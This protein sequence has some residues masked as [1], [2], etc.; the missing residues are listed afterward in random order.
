LKLFCLL[1]S[2][3]LESVENLRGASSKRL[4]D[5][6]NTAAA[7][8]RCLHEGSGNRL[9]RFCSLLKG[10]LAADTAANQTDDVA[11]QQSSTASNVLAAMARK[12][13]DRQPIVSTTKNKLDSSFA[14]LR[15]ASC[16]IFRT[17]DGDLNDDDFELNLN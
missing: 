15:D 9:K 3:A 11:V 7:D 12:L 2:E 6:S 13:A 1:I 10:D 17:A 4:A 16:A 14:A 8:S 5:E